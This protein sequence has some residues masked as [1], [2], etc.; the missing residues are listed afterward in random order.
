MRAVMIFTTWAYGKSPESGSYPTWVSGE[1]VTV[2]SSDSPETVYVETEL[3]EVHR[4]QRHLLFT[5][6]D[7]AKASLS[8]PMFN[9]ILAYH[10]YHLGA[11]D[12]VNADAN[13]VR[14]KLQLIGGVLS[15]AVEQQND[16]RDHRNAAGDNGEGAA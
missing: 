3:G 16:H 13:E 9:L 1:R 11:H 8:R 5:E 4:V 12:G 7:I 2:V 10:C 14:R 6:E 15:N